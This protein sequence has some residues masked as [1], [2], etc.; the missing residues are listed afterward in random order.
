MKVGCRIP[1]DTFAQIR[2]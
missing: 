1:M 2:S